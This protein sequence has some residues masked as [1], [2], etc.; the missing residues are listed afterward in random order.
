MQLLCVVSL[1]A[2][3]LGVEASS[4]KTPSSSKVLSKT[5][6]P[7]T[8]KPSTPLPTTATAGSC[9]VSPDT[10]FQIAILDKASSNNYDD[11]NISL[12]DIGG[13]SQLAEFTS[14]SSTEL[15]IL[16]EACHLLL[17][18]GSYA[19]LEVATTIPKLVE[20]PVVPVRFQPAQQQYADGSA[21][22]TC[23]VHPK[24]KAFSCEAD[25]MDTWMLCGPNEWS[26]GMPA[27]VVGSDGWCN[28]VSLEVIF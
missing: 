18:N 19:A 2:L 22:L 17:F 23:S 6:S 20:N 1:L 28:K 8:K 24:S 7:T 11:Y 21:N 9:G 4:I 15:F 26:L 13:E 3:F 16:D 27:A 12:I 25:G 14:T 10:T 5:K